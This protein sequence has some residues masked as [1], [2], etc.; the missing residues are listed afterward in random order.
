MIVE[1]PVY[2]HIKKLLYYNVLDPKAPLRAEFHNRLGL[3]I[4]AILHSKA[5]KS[6]AND[7]M[8]ET[9]QVEVNDWLSKMDHRVKKLV[10]IN[11]YFDKDFKEIMFHSVRDQY[12]AGIPALQAVKIFLKRLEITEDEYSYE[13]AYRCWLR[14]KNFEY[15]KQKSQKKSRLRPKTLAVTS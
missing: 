1:I 5:E 11:D 10:K 14:E 12:H 8:T 3:T 9:I 4:R 13:T 6:Q 7:R 15:E 2:P